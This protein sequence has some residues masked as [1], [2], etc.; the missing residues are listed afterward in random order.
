MADI[1]ALN[2]KRGNLIDQIS[3]LAAET[4]GLERSLAK[5]ESDLQFAS[6]L[7]L[8]RRI[9][10]RIDTYRSGIRTNQG[11][12]QRLQTELRTVE[13]QINQAQ[14]Q[15]SAQVSSGQVVKQSQ[16][17]RDDSASATNP[18]P[19]AQTVNA[20]G[21]IV[22][23]NPSPVLSNAEE[24][25]PGLTDAGT[26]AP[27]RKAANL[28]STPPVTAR[29]GG[30]NRD[31]AP[32]PT[33]NNGA[34]NP[35][36]DAAGSGVRARL[37]NLFGG[38]NN[39]IVPQANIL[40]NYASYTYNISIYIMSPEDYSKMLK[41]KQRRLYGAQLLMQSGG[42]P[43]SGV[44]NQTGGQTD[45][46]EIPGVTTQSAG[47]NVTG[48]N[49]FF[50]LDYYIDDVEVRSLIS[51]KG[52]NGAHNV[53]ELKFKIIE[54]NGITFLDNLF[55]A[56]QQYIKVSGS[57]VNKNYAAQNFLMVIR[58]YG[59]D[60]F[61]N[62]VK[63]SK[64]GQDST[65]SDV[66][67]IVEKFIPFQFTGIRF[68]IANRLVEYDCSAVCP[69]NAVNTGAS[70]GV[71]PYNVELQSQTLKDLLTGTQQFA[72][73]TETEGRATRAANSTTAPGARTP[74]NTQG[75]GMISDIQGA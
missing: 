13:T 25:V 15:Q 59:Y 7:R 19:T 63:V 57:D 9:Q 56:T 34:A 51:G 71:I 55:A 44:S 2:V 28:Q 52:T 47:L 75:L 18:P 39:R 50:P 72:A 40:D 29:P 64:A 14:Q 31:D 8:Q 49:Q 41:S 17:A 70:R 66:N 38:V 35:G 43:V 5:A 69:Q 1:A 21:R 67:A 22:K 10:Q 54:N 74:T 12:T 73:A 3:S 48:R 62:L 11:I 37:N 61:G 24:F 32:Q 4:A 58:F 68:R 6:D 20:A 36:D 26:N 45:P 60:E 42:A 65:G 23:T 27:V 33:V 30:I 53:T 46:G 16:A